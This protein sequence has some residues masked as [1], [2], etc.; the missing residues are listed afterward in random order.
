MSMLFQIGSPTLAPSLPPVCGKHICRVQGLITHCK[1]YNLLFN[2]VKHIDLT[3]NDACFLLCAGHPLFLHPA[4]FISCRQ[5]RNPEGC[6]QRGEC[7]H[8]Q[9]LLSVHCDSWEANGGRWPW[10]HLL[11]VLHSLL[12]P[13][14]PAEDAVAQ[15]VQVSFYFDKYAGAAETYIKTT[16]V[17]MSFMRH[18]NQ[19]K[20]SSSSPFSICLM[21]FSALYLPQYDPRVTKQYN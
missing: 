2:N 20:S 18:N 11:T 7:V 5:L 21:L 19:I 17:V 1:S 10:L 4:E 12:S 14:S 6:L 9:L 8:H 13:C 15:T 16:A 3:L